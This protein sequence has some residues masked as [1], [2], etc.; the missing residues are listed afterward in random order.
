MKRAASPKRFLHVVSGLTIVLLASI[1]AWPQQQPAAPQSPLQGV[2]ITQRM[3]QQVPA[4]LV[5]HDATGR[6]VRLGD[7]FG[8]KPTVL[9]LVYF[10][11]PFLCTDVLN[12]ELRALQG[13]S[14]KLGKD[15]NAVTVSFD[16]QDG[17]I[18]AAEKTRVYNGFYGSRSVPGDWHFLTGDQASIQ[19]LTQA[20]GFNYSYDQPS[21]QFAH[22]TAIMILTPEGLVSRYFYG[23]QYPT[24][25]VRLG[26]VEAS[27]GRIGS[28]TD[29]ALLYCFHYDPMTGK[30]GLIIS[31]V[32][33]IVG[34]A[35]VLVLGIC[36]FLMF[37]REN[38][39]LPVPQAAPPVSARGVSGAGRPRLRT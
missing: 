2:G 17:P 1:S 32:I 3:N 24:R 14:L 23:V 29:A 25:D 21:G 9:S 20:V 27:E 6:T 31:N 39:G 19:S 36:V 22:A 18:D 4:D 7:Y 8:Q 10:N 35:T 11:C 38:Y 5:F 37:R 34:V 28:P 33:R 30:Y 13:I 15:Y 26:L 12:G 16:P